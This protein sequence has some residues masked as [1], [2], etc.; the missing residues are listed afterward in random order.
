M[1]Q[2]IKTINQAAYF[3]LEISMLVALSYSAFQ[4]SR[5]TFWEYVLAI[6]LLLLVATF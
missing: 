1:I 6:G 5:H 2:I 3:F 4:S